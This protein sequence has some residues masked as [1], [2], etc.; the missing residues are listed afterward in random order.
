MGWIAHH[1]PSHC[2]PEGHQ[3]QDQGG[4]CVFGPCLECGCEQVFDDVGTLMCLRLIVSSLS[5][6][7]GCTLVGKEVL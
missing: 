1:S 7:C 5:F 6:L 2:S 4:V 3:V